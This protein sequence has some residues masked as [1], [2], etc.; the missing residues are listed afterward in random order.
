MSVRRSSCEVMQMQMFTSRS[1]FAR[2][3]AGSS[4]SLQ[5][6]DNARSVASRRSSQYAEEQGLHRSQGIT[7]VHRVFS[8]RMSLC[9]V[10]AR[11][12]R[13]FTN[14]SG[15]ACL[16]SCV[17][18]SVAIT[19][20]PCLRTALN[21]WIE[22]NWISKLLPHGV[23]NVDGAAGVCHSRQQAM[24]SKRNVPWSE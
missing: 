16:S 19:E 14:M 10:Y 18:L 21:H 17:L 23:S 24:V 9:R 20:Y 7:R 3:G 6:N 2:E 1:C 13:S 15:E 4:T 5:H 8:S 22:S 12:P 11:V